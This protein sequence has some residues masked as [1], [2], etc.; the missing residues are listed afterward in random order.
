MLWIAKCAQQIR[1]NAIS[2]LKEMWTYHKW[3]V[4]TDGCLTA[5]SAPPLSRNH[6]LCSSSKIWTRTK[7]KIIFFSIFIYRNIIF[8]AS[9]VHNKSPVF[10][11]PGWSHKSKMCISGH[12]ETQIYIW[13]C[14]WLLHTCCDR[15][16]QRAHSI[17]VLSSITAGIGSCNILNPITQNKH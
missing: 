17:T 4:G 6:T 5:T 11:F 16:N 14:S 15:M 7:H 9:L 8:E 1:C 10:Q 2:K 12:L 3:R 13:V